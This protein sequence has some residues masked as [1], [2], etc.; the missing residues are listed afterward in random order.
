MRD[1]YICTKYFGYNINY[2]YIRNNT[3]FADSK[4]FIPIKSYTC[5][6][7]YGDQLLNL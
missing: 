1:T 3:F 2:V 7:P 4:K 6:C 5:S